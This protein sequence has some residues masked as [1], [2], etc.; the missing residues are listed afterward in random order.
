ME[1]DDCGSQ[2]AVTTCID[3][4]SAGLGN[5]ARFQAHVIAR[6]QTRILADLNTAF[7]GIFG[8]SRSISVDESQDMGLMAVRE[9]A[10][11]AT[12]KPQDIIGIEIRII[13]NAGG[14]SGLAPLDLALDAADHASLPLLCQGDQ[15]LP[16]CCETVD[17]PRPGDILTHCFRPFPG[18]PVLKDGTVRDAVHRA[19]DHGVLFDVGHGIGSFSWGKSRAML[20]AGFLPDNI[21]SDVHALSVQNPAWDHLRP[22]TRILTLGQTLSQV[23]ASTTCAP[24]PALRRLGLGTLKPDGTGDAIIIALTDHPILFE[25]ALAETVIQPQN[26]VAQGR[27]LSGMLHD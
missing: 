4:A 1:A 23:I 6:A 11:V 22:M 18:A 16:T 25:D 7:A 26:L 19:R 21:S 27:V 8:F 14:T 10:Q 9:V 13:K 17:C 2:S 20:A 12:D 24:A 15:V 3:T 5:H